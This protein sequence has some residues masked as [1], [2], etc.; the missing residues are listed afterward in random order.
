MYRYLEECSQRAVKLSSLTLT[1]STIKLIRNPQKLYR[2]QLLTTL[3]ITASAKIATL[4]TLLARRSLNHRR[5]RR[6]VRKWGG[7]L[8]GGLDSLGRISTIE[9]QPLIFHLLTSW[10]VQRSLN[11]ASGYVNK[12]ELSTLLWYSVV[13]FVYMIFTVYTDTLW[14]WLVVSATLEQS[15]MLAWWCHNIYLGKD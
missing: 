13:G 9:E 2:G 8:L 14:V 1:V 4:N 10:T 15:C 3:Q 7:E 6:Q 5:R 12:R 11:S